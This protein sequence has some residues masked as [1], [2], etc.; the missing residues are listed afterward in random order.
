[1]VL[2]VVDELPSGGEM[3][4]L[5]VNLPPGLVGEPGA[6]PKC[7]RQQFDGE[8]CPPSSQIGLDYASVSGLGS[9]QDL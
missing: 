1:M 7:T 8:E 3:H 9:I 2:V 6:M 4:A 5:N